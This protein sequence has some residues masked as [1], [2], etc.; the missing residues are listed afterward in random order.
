MALYSATKK[1]FSKKPRMMTARTQNCRRTRSLKEHSIM[2]IH[3][4]P[5]MAYT[6]VMIP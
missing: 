4:T 3:T 5:K 1:V 2:P 6:V